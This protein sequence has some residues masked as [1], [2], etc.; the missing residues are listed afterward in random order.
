MATRTLEIVAKVRDQA[1]QSLKRMEQRLYKV[2]AAAKKASA[3]FA[4]LNKQL[5]ITDK[6]LGRSTKNWNKMGQTTTKSSRN[7]EKSN[8]VIKNTGKAVQNTN[9]D[10]T[11]FNRTMFS[12]TAFVGLFTLAFR[13]MTQAMSEGAGLDRLSNQVERVFGDKG[14]FLKSVRDTTDSSIDM[15]E[16]MRAGISLASLGIVKDSK[17]AADLIA[18]AGV[19]AKLAGKDSAEGIKQFSEFMKDGSVQH[20]EFLNLIH[21]TNPALKIQLAALKKYGDI[22][23]GVL[24]NSH[25]LA[26][27]QKVLFLATK[28]SMRGN[29]DLY[30]SMRDIGQGM[31]FASKAA[32][33]FIT[34]GLVPIFDKVTAL[35]WKFRESTREHQKNSKSLVFLGKTAMVATVALSGLT[36]TLGTMR[37]MAIAL[38]SLGIGV[39]VLTGAI[40]ALAL[41]FVSTTHGTEGFMEKLKLFGG[42]FQ[43]TWQLVSSFLSSPENFA[44][45]IGLMDKSLHDML[46]KAG[47]LGLVKGLARAAA[48]AYQFGAGMKEGVIKTLKDVDKAIGGPLKKLLELL[49]L[50]PERWSRSWLKEMKNI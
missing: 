17:Q 45:G 38:S 20:L 26:I 48:L 44:K 37:L 9:A 23:G 14:T 8:K 21:R 2:G 41:A 11:K 16:A 46:K 1:S 32:V 6:A 13:S 34:K 4:I 3:G 35:L 5:N 31:H 29:R 27:G 36:A 47:L 7:L 49:N 39:P 25:K 19:A 24:S 50:G 28:D 15:T 22:A 43:G 18:R 33:N 40:G 10:F 42:V 30:D 12:T